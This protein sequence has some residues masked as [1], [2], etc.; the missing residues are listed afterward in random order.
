MINQKTSSCRNFQFT[1][2]KS[3]PLKSPGSHSNETNYIQVTQKSEKSRRLP[4]MPMWLAI[5]M[6]THPWLLFYLDYGSRNLPTN[7]KQKKKMG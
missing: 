6:Y 1:D 5:Y 7:K 4:T 2:K 3:F